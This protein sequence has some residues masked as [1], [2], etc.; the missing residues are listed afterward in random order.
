VAGLGG[1]GGIIGGALAKTYP[2]VSFL[3]RG[4]RLNSIRQNGLIIKSEF[5]GD[6]Q[7][8]P[9]KLSDHADELGVMDY[10]FICV[11]N[12]SLEQ[13][14]RQISPMV[15]ESTVIIPIMNGIDPAE[16]T[17]S[18][19]CKGIV[20]DALIYIASG[21]TEDFTVVQKGKY[22]SVHIGF[23]NPSGKEE[24]AIRNVHEILTEAGIQCTVDE[25]IEAVIWKKYVL[26][27]AFNIITAYYH[28]NT[29]DIR[30]DP[31]KVEAFKSLMSE[32]CLIGRKKGVNL[33]PDT[34]EDHLKHLLYRQSEEATS[35]LRRDMDLQ[36]ENELETFSGYLLG[37]GRQ[38]G[39]ELP[40]TQL[41]YDRLKSR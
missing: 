20:L 16:R 37:L 27:C 29:G 6:F 38:Y 19:L 35:S 22:A 10:I 32:A 31:E 24:E 15:G 9:E 17:R 12:Y 41:F 7:I 25:D 11:K 3:A 14:C 39:L 4:A 18:Y 26:N 21:C 8:R 40:V 28:A 23:E 34:E 2:H 30:K 33:T 1:V 5:I 13:L 36:K